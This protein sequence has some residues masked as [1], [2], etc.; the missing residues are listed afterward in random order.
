MTLP[1]PPLPTP[2]APVVQ[3]IDINNALVIDHANKYQLLL[4]NI[5]QNITQQNATIIAKEGAN[6]FLI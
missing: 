3:G 2:R 6:K 5:S 4:A 1:V